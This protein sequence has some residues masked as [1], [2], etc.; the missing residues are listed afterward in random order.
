VSLLLTILKA[1]ILRGEHFFHV[2][3]DLCHCFRLTVCFCHYRH[4]QNSPLEPQPVSEDAVF[5]S[6]DFATIIFYTAKTEREVKILFLVSGLCMLYHNFYYI[7][8][9]IQAA[10]AR[11]V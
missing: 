6:L 8:P 4:C 3:P 1:S 7:F 2:V 11:S 10:V 9:D 5:T